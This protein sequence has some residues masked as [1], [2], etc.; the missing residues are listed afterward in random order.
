MER[1]AR[2]ITRHELQADPRQLREVLQEAARDLDTA[3]SETRRLVVLLIGA[4]AN[5]WTRHKYPHNGDSLI[6]EIDR[7]PDRVRVE[8]FSDATVRAGFWRELGDVV[9]PGL[10]FRWG[11]ERRHRPGTW[12]EVSAAS[13]GSPSANAF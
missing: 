12:F 2:T 9:A 11:V 1:R 8:V 4:L 3:D 10:A 6:L 7:L 13:G 5:Q